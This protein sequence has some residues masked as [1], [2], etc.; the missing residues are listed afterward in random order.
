M[1]PT[2]SSLHVLG[3]LCLKPYIKKTSEV[4][5]NSLNARSSFSSQRKY[6]KSKDKKS[7]MFCFRTW[8][9]WVAFLLFLKPKNQHA[10]PLSF[11]IY[12]NK[13]R[14]LSTSGVRGFVYNHATMEKGG[15]KLSKKGNQRAQAN[16]RTQKC[17]FVLSCELD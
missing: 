1:S 10:Q 12:H 6:S 11:K 15:K 9:Q 4:L 5:H 2:R 14:G 8:Q 16:F 17:H 13:T 7:K 3:Q